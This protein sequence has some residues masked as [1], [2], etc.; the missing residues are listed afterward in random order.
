MISMR[1]PSGTRT[2]YKEAL[3]WEDYEMKHPIVI[4]WALS[5]EVFW[6]TPQMLPGYFEDVE[7]LERLLHKDKKLRVKLLWQGRVLDPSENLHRLFDW[8]LRSHTLDAV[9]VEP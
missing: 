7:D 6:Q 5:G 1:A 9:R 2:S 8:H 4:R 3:P